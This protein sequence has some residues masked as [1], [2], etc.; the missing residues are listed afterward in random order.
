MVD[1]FGGDSLS[2]LTKFAAALEKVAHGNRRVAKD[3]EPLV[4]RLA[5]LVEMSVSH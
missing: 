3:L 2:C 5:T 4:Q 1:A